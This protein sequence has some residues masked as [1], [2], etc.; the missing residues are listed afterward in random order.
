MRGTYLVDTANSGS[1]VEISHITGKDAF[2]FTQV[3]RE[4]QSII[5]FTNAGI[6]KSPYEAQVR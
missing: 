1:K 5:R 2:I 4:E 6:Q 3:A